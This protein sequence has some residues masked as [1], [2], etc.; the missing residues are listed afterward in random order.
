MPSQFLRKGRQATPA[1][2]TLLA[3]ESCG[4]AAGVTGSSAQRSCSSRAGQAAPKLLNAGLPALRYLIYREPPSPVGAIGHSKYGNRVEIWG[5]PKYSSA[6]SSSR[7][8][9]FR[10]ICDEPVKINRNR[11]NQFVVDQISDVADRARPNAASRGPSELYAKYPANAPPEP[12]SPERL[13]V[14]FEKSSIRRANSA[15]VGSK[16]G[17]TTRPVP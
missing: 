11:L 10:S 3:A 7:R 1:M 12:S 13:T 2:Q 9:N 5:S 16:Q 15:A 4:Y 14:V 6:P 8:S 17:R